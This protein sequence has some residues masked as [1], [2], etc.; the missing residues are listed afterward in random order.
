MNRMNNK[1]KEGSTGKVTESIESSASNNF[2]KG[3][4]RDAG[5]SCQNS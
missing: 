3:E 4:G 5:V 2:S 1:A